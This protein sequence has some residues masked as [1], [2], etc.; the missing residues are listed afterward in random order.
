[1][2]FLLVFL[3]LFLLADGWNRKVAEADTKL[4]YLRQLIIEI[5]YKLMLD[6][7]ADKTNNHEKFKSKE[8]SC[9]SLDEEVTRDWLR[10]TN[11]EHRIEMNRN[12]VDSWNYESNITDATKQKM[13]ESNVRFTAYERGLG[14]EAAKCQNENFSNDTS[15]KLKLLNQIFSPKDPKRVKELEDLEADLT[16]IYGNAV[17]EINGKKLQIEPELT[18]IM[19]N[20]R[21][22]TELREAWE[23]WRNVTGAK[24]KTKYTR[25]VELQN[26]GASDNGYTSQAE[27]W[28]TTDFD[29]IA[30][31]EDMCDRLW[32]ELK[33]LYSELHKYVRNKLKDFYK[34]DV[35]FPDDG[36]I[37]AHLLGN[38]WAQEFVGI[39]DIVKPYDIQNEN[40]DEV[41]KEQGYTPRKM[42]EKAEEFYVSLGLPKMTGKFWKNSIIEKPT[43]R[44][45][46][47]HASAWDLYDDGDFRIKMCTNMT[48]DYFETIHHEM[49][50]I[51][52]YMAYEDQPV[53][54]R[55]GANGGFHEAIGDTI[56]NAVRTPTHLCELIG[57]AC[58]SPAVDKQEADLNYLMKKA[59]IKVAFLPFG[60]LI[61][62]Y[63]WAVFRG[64]IKPDEYNSEW[65]R[66]RMEYQMISPPSHRGEEYFDPGAKYHVAASVPYIRYFISF[67]VQFQFYESMCKAA[68]HGHKPLHQCDFYRNKD[69]GQKL[70]DMMSLGGS[71]PWPEALKQMTGELDIS[72]GSIM[73]YFQPLLDWMKVENRKNDEQNN[74]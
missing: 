62:K 28:L 74:L 60:L 2:K 29:E 42:F 54:Y 57:V 7:E 30:G 68:G 23:K 40:Y 13:T 71:K 59:L 31:I 73:R 6:I 39:F 11:E 17:V 37:P 33:P 43:D 32:S 27:V 67:V 61:D 48:M 10:R 65:W 45:L 46:V 15:R 38:M 58:A 72:A 1:M 44:S 70:H 14:E 64:S 24:M 69:A 18:E 55:R 22:E 34:N 8:R 5:K 26:I 4:D 21:N 3:G 66:M 36:S 25:L 19:A 49:G 41:L 51:Q 16:E 50:H 35:T 47:C 20:S 52:Y 12:V 63:R 53:V 9:S 56:A